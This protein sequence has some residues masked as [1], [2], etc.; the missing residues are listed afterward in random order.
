MAVRRALLVIICFCTCLGVWASEPLAVPDKIR[1]A[2]EAWDD[3]TE[4][5]GRGMAWDI[6]REVFEP[7]GLL[8][9]IRS[10]PY[11][12]SVGLV[13][14]GEVDALVGAYRDEMSGVLYPRW[15]Y[16][17]DHIYCLGL[18]SKPAPT[19][20]TLG[21][22][23]LVWVRGYKYQQYLPNI[24]SYNE[25]RRRIGILPMLMYNRAD[26][27]IDA[28]TEVDYVLSQ[29]KDPS[30]FRRTHLAELPLYIGF[31]DNDRGRALRTLFD[32]RMDEL[33]KSQR[34]RPIFERWHQ[35]YPFESGSA[36]LSP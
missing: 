7:S 35:P 16:D 36:E 20:A 17:T 21:G 29:A 34:L 15:N 8:L 6:L 26:Y 3:Y 28:L 1:L 14:R 11:T 9:D 31:A 4:A 30:L 25:V 33:V 10:V 32:Q 27:Y 22:Y 23:R 18:A 13:Q 12:R 24:V 2:S 19:L 5:S